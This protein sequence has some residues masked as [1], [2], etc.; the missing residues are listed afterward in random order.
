L[1]SWCPTTRRKTSESQVWASKPPGWSSSDRMVFA[2]S[3]FELQWATEVFVAARERAPAMRP[4]QRRRG[5]HCSK[6]CNVQ[7]S[8]SRFREDRRASGRTAGWPV[9]PCCERHEWDVAA[10]HARQL[11]GTRRVPQANG[12]GRRRPGGV[13]LQA[14]CFLIFSAR[15]RRRGCRAF[16]RSPRSR[17]LMVSRAWS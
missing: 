12:S 13:G 10:G 2:P 5:D 17:P 14:L 8:S 11:R 16:F 3:R 7:A 15:D 9:H 6:R 1:A 4:L